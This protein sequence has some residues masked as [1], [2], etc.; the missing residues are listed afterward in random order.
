M[1]AARLEPGWKVCAASLAAPKRYTISIIRGGEYV[2]TGREYKG[3]A[4]KT[5]AKLWMRTHL[6]TERP[7]LPLSLSCSG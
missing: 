1:M 4:A 5:R 7:L 2:L 3:S 6:R